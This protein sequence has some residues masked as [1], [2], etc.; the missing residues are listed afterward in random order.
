VRAA[1]AFLVGAC[2][3]FALLTVVLRGA[4]AGLGAEV[5]SALR[6]HR[7]LERA[8]GESSA[9]VEELRAPAR[10]AERLSPPRGRARE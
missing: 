4:A 10:I 6:R 9:E 7:A 8:L 2:F 5:D 3:A 1:S